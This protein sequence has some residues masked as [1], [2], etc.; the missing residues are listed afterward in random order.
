MSQREQPA[1][2][3]KKIKSNNTTIPT[4]I[5]GP[6]SDS[7]LSTEVVSASELGTSSCSSSV[8]TLRPLSRQGAVSDSPSSA[9]SLERSGDMDDLG[10]VELSLEDTG[11]KGRDDGREGEVAVHGGAGMSGAGVPVGTDGD[12]LTNRELRQIIRSLALV[13]P[14]VPPPTASVSDQT[15]K[16]QGLAH[17]K[18]GLDIAKYI[19]KLEADLTDIGVA[20]REF[21]SI[22]FQKL[23]SKSAAQIVASIDR[24]DCTYEELKQTLI[25]SLGSGKTSLGSKLTTEFSGDVRHMNSLEKYVHLK[26]LIDS[27]NMSIGDHKDILLFF[28]S[29]IYRNSLSTHQKSIMDSREINTFRD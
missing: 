6:L 17:H 20:R 23:S 28:A 18:D 25:D 19:R 1:K 4:L 27:V 21:K 24:D 7:G 5:G 22:L 14:T 15:R 2:A 13:R 3:C 9:G 8:V 12:V 11:E 29:A 26:C 10:E 16:V